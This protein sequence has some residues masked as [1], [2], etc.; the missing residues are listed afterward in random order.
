MFKFYENLSF[1][2]S[3]DHKHSDWSQDNPYSYRQWYEEDITGKDTLLIQIGDSWTWGDHLGCIDWDKAS[4]DPCRQEQIVGRKLSNLLDADWVN[5]AKPGCSNYWMLEQLQN[6]EPHLHRVQ[7]QYQRICVVVTL[8][9]DLRESKYSRRINVDRPYKSFWDDSASIKDFLI[10]VE[11][12]LLLNLETYFKNLPFVQV[13]I[14]RAFTDVWPEN[15]SPLL[16]P[17][18]WCDVIQDKINFDNYQKPV[19]FIGQMSIDP[20]TEK[21]IAH[22]PERKQEFLDIMDRVATRWNFLGASDYNLKGSTCH[23]NPA[24]HL[25]WAEYLYSQLNTTVHSAE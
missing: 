11:S 22:R 24:G 10:K 12:Y 19:P 15:E 21:F 14:A 23:P 2:E 9:E 20:L 7:N 3:L 8:T 5:L 13:K 6:I 18:S 1:D 17:K 25:L 4:N 16:L